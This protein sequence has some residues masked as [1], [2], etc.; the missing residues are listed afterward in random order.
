MRHTNNIQPR[1]VT[2]TAVAAP[3]P[4]WL[5]PVLLG[6]IYLVWGSTYLGIQVAVRGDH[7]FPP[8]LLGAIR[9]GTAGVVL[10]SLAAMFGRP[11]RVRA[12]ELR[13]HAISGLLLWVAGNGL[14]IWALRRVD[15][16]YAALLMSATP[17]F[18]VLLE[19]GLA[20]RAPKVALGRALALGTAGIAL[21]SAPA[22]LGGAADPLGM[23]ALL[24]AGLAWAVGT[25]YQ[26]R[27]DVS[28]D[29]LASAG[30][31]LV[32]AGLG[33]AAVAAL[34]GEAAP[35]PS[36]EAWAALAYLIL[37]GSVLG[38]GSYVWALR[39]LPAPVVM[40]HAY[41]NP[42]VAVLLGWALLGESLTVWTWL[43][44]GLVLM[45]VV[46]TLRRR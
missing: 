6:V 16:G 35:S 41:V 40:T 24:T 34:R 26:Q 45:G 14:V 21:L 9:L 22:L 43:G 44:T 28:G 42:V 20:R 31:Q 32:F 10:L 23:A 39:L 7:G 2:A 1:A 17:V 29:P 4:T 3:L 37:V 33:F 15:T 46:E 5:G 11:I 13:V 36:P 27:R 18:V 19:A 25:I 30:W 12:A 8:F 38:F